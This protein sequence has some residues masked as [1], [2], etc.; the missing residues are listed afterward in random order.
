MNRRRDPGAEFIVEAC[1]LASLA[2][3]ALR[4]G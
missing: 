1:I 2:G 4:A 3:R